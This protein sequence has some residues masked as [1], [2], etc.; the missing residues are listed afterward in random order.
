MIFISVWFLVARISASLGECC[1]AVCTLLFVITRCGGVRGRLLTS[2]V[3]LTLLGLASTKNE[4]SPSGRLCGYYPGTL[5]S[6]SS[7]CISR[8]YRVPDLHKSCSDLTW[9]IMTASC[10]F[11]Y[12][13][14]ISQLSGFPLYCLVSQW[15]RPI[16]C[17]LLALHPPWPSKRMPYF[18][19]NAT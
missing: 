17:T 15:R 2:S 16:N 19:W 18:V 4:T 9:S 14:S 7:Y 13:N 11:D 1:I 6:L 3:I 5:S 8:E 10:G 12:Y